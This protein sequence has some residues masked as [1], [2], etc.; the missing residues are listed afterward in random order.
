MVY[1]THSTPQRSAVLVPT[2][3]ALLDNAVKQALPV[4]WTILVGGLVL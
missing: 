4:T 3:L 2:L 1:Y